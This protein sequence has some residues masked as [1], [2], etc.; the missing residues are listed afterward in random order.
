MKYLDLQAIYVM[1][2]RQMKRF[3]RSKSRIAITIIQPLFF[4]FILGSGFSQATIPG[5]EGGEYIHFLA[6][7]IIAMAIMFSSMF[8]GISVLWDKPL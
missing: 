4:L 3:L 2:L 1:W 7:G 8:T 5:V 6:P